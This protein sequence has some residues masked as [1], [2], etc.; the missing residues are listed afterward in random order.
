MMLKEEWISY[1]KKN[2]V[3]PTKSLGQNFL[4][5]NTVVDRI[6]EAA[7]LCEEDYVLEIGSGLGVLTESLVAS[8]AMVTAVEIDKHIA[9]LLQ[10]R[11]SY[12]E[13]PGGALQIRI[14]DFL[15]IE[16]LSLKREGSLPTVCISNLPYYITTDIMMKLF[17]YQED[18][19]VMVFMVEKAAC[20]RIFA[21]VGSKS[22]GPL[23][24]ISSVYGTK[25][26]LFDVHAS[27]FYPQP[28]TLS[29]VIRLT[30][31]GERQAVPTVF[32]SLVRAAFAQRR[33]TLMNALSQSALF[34]GGKEQTKK[35]IEYSGLTENSRA[36]EITPEQYVQLARDLESFYIR[37]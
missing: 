16:Y 27:S 22:Y 15:K 17:R 37:K 2:R 8:N 9:P 21:G 13:D 24:V 28:H 26:R 6:V 18:F 20:E 12:T 19:R 32:F 11:L 30:R 35:F 1:I 3:V 33:K 4:V 36:E 7:G 23:S 31:D 5:E 10:K 29:A 34:P 25:E 14:E